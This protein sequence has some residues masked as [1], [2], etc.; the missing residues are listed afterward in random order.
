MTLNAAAAEPYMRC[1]DDEPGRDDIRCPGG[2]HGR[3]TDAATITGGGAAGTS[4]TGVQ[5]WTTHGLPRTPWQ[6]VAA[7]LSLSNGHRTREINGRRFPS[8]A[9]NVLSQRRVE[10]SGEDT[11][12][13]PAEFL[14]HR[15]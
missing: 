12:S 15:T 4:R 3:S 11:T 7:Q 6:R 14:S 13:W 5:L 1:G 2:R 9:G 8:S 10:R